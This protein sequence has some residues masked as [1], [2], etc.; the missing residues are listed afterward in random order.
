MSKLRV[1][2]LTLV[3][4]LTVAACQK[5][6]EPP[7][8]EKNELTTDQQKFGYSIGVNIGKQLQS[9]KEEIDTKALASG[10]ED[11]LTGAPLKLDDAARDEIMRTVSQKIQQ[12][13]AEEH[14]K[15]GEK[16]KVDGE[17]FLADNKVK[18]NIKTTASGLQYEV[19]TE[20]KGPAPTAKDT[21]KVNYKGTLI[22]GTT[23]DS[24]YDRGQPITFPLAGVIP[25][26]TEGVQLMKTGGKYKLY[27]P[28]N[29]AYGERAA[30]EKIG[31]NSTLIFEIEL[32]DIEK[33]AEK[34]KK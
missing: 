11:A 23:F 6:P 14:Q 28:S 29:L 8:V 18:P 26:W 3:V 10:L 19:I 24:S 33:P 1:T 31:P 12:K 4:G 9:G 2:A 27:V 5:A 15:A 13:Q 7:K 32:L 21:V 34:P 17:K 25:G 20:G 16:N 22:D 30:G